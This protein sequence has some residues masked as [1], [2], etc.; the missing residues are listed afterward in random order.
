MTVRTASATRLFRTRC[1]HCRRLRSLTAKSKI[2]RHSVK[3]QVCPG[4]GLQI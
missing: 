4:S 3:G 1:P 2:R